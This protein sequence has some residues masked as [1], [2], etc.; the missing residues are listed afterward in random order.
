MLVIEGLVESIVYRS[1]KNSYTVARLATEDGMLTIV[2][3]FPYQPI[4]A[5]IKASGEMIYHD[6]YGEQFKVKRLLSKTATFSNSMEAYL[7]SGAIDYIGPTLAERIIDQFGDQT[8]DIFKN[9]P[10]KLM[11]VPGIGKKTYKKIMDSFN[12]QV[13]LRDLMIELSNYGISKNLGEKLFQ[14]YGDGVLE[15][16]KKNPYLLIDAVDGISFRTADQIAKEAGVKENDPNRIEAAMVYLLKAASNE[17]SSYLPYEDLKLRT[18]DFLRL[19]DKDIENSEKNFATNRNISLVQEGR[20]VKAYLSKLYSCENYIALKINKLNKTGLYC[21]LASIDSKISMIESLENINFAPQQKEAIK[22]AFKNRVLIITGGPGTGKT[23]TLKA[24]LHIAEEL[25]IS[26]CL[27]APTGRAAKRMEEAT[28]QESKTIHRLLEYQ[29]NGSHMVFGKNEENLLDQEMVIVDEMSMVDTQ[30]LTDLLR[31]MGSRSRLI[32]LGDVNQIPSVG[33]GNILKDLIGSSLLPIVELKKIFRQEGGSKIV[34]NAHRINQGYLPLLNE[35]GSDFFMIASKS[36]VE[37]VNNIKSLVATRL[38]NFYGFD[39]KKDI[40]IMTPMKKGLVGVEN[41]NFELQNS[42]NPPDFSKDELV[43]G[44]CV[45]RLGDKVMQTKNNYQ[46]E[47]EAYTEDR[48]VYDS[49]SGIYN[50]DIGFIKKV[51]SL[52]RTLVVDFDGREVSYTEEDLKDLTLAY[53]ITIHKSQGSEFP[54]VIIPIHYAPELLANR[55]LIYTAITRAKKLVVL[56]GK[57]QRLKTMIDNT[58]VNER[59]TGLREKIKDF[60]RVVIG[61]GKKNMFNL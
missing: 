23:T 55:N 52:S 18:K 59:F 38:K 41:L 26:Y 43:F 27:A 25:G 22:S 31:A 49:G 53:A 47:W 30:L 14:K 1:E 33:P 50:G 2:G 54:V 36:E 29:F 61:D 8:Y 12:D 34:D 48:I 60:N 46:M 10:E 58:Y 17:G 40:Q 51:N 35:K 56:V 15:V 7:R 5:S 57:E 6:K 20:I 9:T 21:P 45:F 16:I 19:E 13:D 28:G 37:T 11:E 4:G 39:P 3:Y 42:L 24:I 32:L 44:A